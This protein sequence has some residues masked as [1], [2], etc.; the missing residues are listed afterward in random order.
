[1]KNLLIFFTSLS[2]FAATP[3]AE[4]PPEIPRPSF[5]LYTNVVQMYLN[6]SYTWDYGLG[7]EPYRKFTNEA[8]TIFPYTYFIDK[9]AAGAADGTNTWGSPTKPRLTHPWPVNAGACVLFRDASTGYSYNNAPS[10]QM[11]IGG[12]GTEALPVF[13]FSAGPSTN[14]ADRAIFSRSSGMVIW[15]QWTVVE[16]FNITNSCTLGTRPALRGSPVTNIV[17]RNNIA[18]GTG[19]SGNQT[20]FS[21]GGSSLTT[22]AN[23][24]AYVRNALV[25]SN[26][27]TAYGDYTSS[28]QQDSLAIMA[29][30]F[31][32]NIWAGWNTVFRMQ[33]DAG[34][35]GTDQD[36]NF[37]QG[38]A[39]FFENDVWENKENA[40][41]VKKANN[42][43]IARNRFH[44]FIPSASSPSG[45][46]L[47]M[48]Y[49]GRN[50]W[51]V[52]NEIYNV[53]RGIVSSGTDNDYYV[54]IIGN[55]IHE[56]LER[57]MY[58][59]RGGGKYLIINNTLKN[60]G[61]GIFMGGNTAGQKL[62]N[63]NNLIYNATNQ[64]LLVSDTGISAASYA[65]HELYWKP[66]G[67][68][69]PVTWGSSVY[70]TIT[71]WI[72][73]TSVGDNSINVD[74][75]FT[76]GHQIATNSLAVDAGF[77]WSAINTLFQSQFTGFATTPTL[78]YDIDGDL[79]GVNGFDIGADEASAGGGG[80]PAVRTTT[81][82][83]IRGKGV[84]FK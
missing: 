36:G 83:G 34:R 70:S 55:Y 35:L 2:V 50:I 69:T 20:F 53:N 28:V 62:T 22:G 14:L 5:G 75:S 68:T 19:V 26:Y 73:G 25:L 48:H 47:T 82:K 45:T 32:T 6:P 15:G 27:I 29:S 79:R 30:E 39:F 81:L 49:G 43:I 37:I 42:C 12:N 56:T 13:V 76:S 4:W 66:A 61:A 72:A 40:I 60:T 23:E 58:P 9:D 59:D 44:T 17:V 63:Y 80:T 1:M 10:S 41:D 3:S 65:S 78:M 18:I 33:G 52:N 84:R 11:A 31:S 74:P 46:P 77:D 64:Y 57:G 8:G 71:D 7:P 67:G 54:G 51:I 38:F 16:G 21:T 24:T